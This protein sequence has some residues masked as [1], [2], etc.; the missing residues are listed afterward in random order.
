MKKYF[1]LLK[2]KEG[3]LKALSVLANPIK[4]DIAPIIELLLEDYDTL[5]TSLTENW[6][7]RGNEIFIDS[8]IVLKIDP[9]MAALNTLLRGLKNASVNIVPV[10]ELNSSD[11]YFELARTISAELETKVC[12]RIKNEF[13]R[14]RLFNPLLAD[15]LARLAIESTNVILLFDLGAVIEANYQNFA[16]SVIANIKGLTNPSQW[17]QIV[18]ASGSFPVDLGGFTANTRNLITR[19]EW[20]IWQEIQ[21]DRELKKLVFYGDY[22]VKHPVFEPSTQ[23]FASSASIKYTTENSYLIYRGI[24]P[25]DHP[26]GNGQYNQKSAL[27]IAD[28]LYDGHAF[29]YADNEIHECAGRTDKPGNAGTWVKIGQSRHIAKIHSLL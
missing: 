18:V 3:E 10:I 15:L 14:P 22:G 6:A 27:L 12:V 26:D 5:L 17:S 21:R 24:R 23:V 20:S 1:P 8:S 16:N 4:K 7:F 13:A 28:A 19:Y 11:E 25:Q 2:S 29:S 9:D